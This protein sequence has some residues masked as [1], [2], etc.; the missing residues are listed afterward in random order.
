MVSTGGLERHV[1]FDARKVIMRAVPWIFRERMG[2]NTEKEFSLKVIIVATIYS[3]T[4]HGQGESVMKE[5]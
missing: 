2:H 3:Y 5:F 4:Q 1:P